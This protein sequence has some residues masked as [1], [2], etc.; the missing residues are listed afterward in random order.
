MPERLFAFATCHAVVQVRKTR[1]Q[2][3]RVQ[4]QTDDLADVSQNLQKVCP[5]TRH[6]PSPW[7]DFPPPVI[8]RRNMKPDSGFF[9]AGRDSIA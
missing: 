8:L 7:A 4:P 2:L 6:P 5:K 9:P 3:Q 1:I